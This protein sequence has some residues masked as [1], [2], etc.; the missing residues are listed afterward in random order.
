MQAIFGSNNS[1]L[2]EQLL[3]FKGFQNKNKN[4]YLY[5]P[6]LTDYCLFKPSLIQFQNKSLFS[7][8]LHSPNIQVNDY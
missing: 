4:E 1:H 3:Y 7:L 2:I 5:F 8:D 6:G